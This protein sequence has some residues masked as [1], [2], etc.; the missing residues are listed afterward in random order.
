MMLFF[1]GLDFITVD[2]NSAE[3]AHFPCEFPCEF[4]L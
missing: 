2:Q 4:P 3:F 1:S